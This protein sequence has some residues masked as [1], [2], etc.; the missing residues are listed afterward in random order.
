M[1]LVFVSPQS[2]GQVSTDSV[3]ASHLPSPQAPPPPPQSLAQLVLVSG[4]SHLPSPQTGIV[5][6]THLL[7]LHVLP[8]TQTPQEDG[9]P[10]IVPQVAPLPVQHAALGQSLMQ[11]I[12]VSP[13]SHLPLPQVA[14]PLQSSGHI[15]IF[16]VGWQMPSPQ[17]P[18]SAQS[19]AQLLG[20]S[21]G[22]HLPL[23]QPSTGLQSAAQLLA[24]SPG[25]HLPLPQLLVT[26]QSLGQD[27]G[28]S[29]ES[30]LPS[31]H[32]GLLSA[33]RQPL[34]LPHE[35]IGTSSASA[36]WVAVFTHPPR[37][38]WSLLHAKA[39][40]ANALHAASAWQAPHSLV[41]LL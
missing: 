34:V 3:A 24:F 33:G 7:P 5:P 19:L 41:H 11:V 25:S 35:S 17:M 36:A 32:L 1:H 10:A 23:P 26:L 4:D 22:S 20:V 12:A 9:Q 27:V 30:H 2:A 29:L 14:L 13:G 16:S 15:S 39:H 38:V 8:P 21:P 40:V 31:P 6:P 37:Q 18:T 28:L